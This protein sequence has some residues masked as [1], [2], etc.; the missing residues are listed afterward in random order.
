VSDSNDGNTA[1]T[2]RLG[3]VSTPAAT[4]VGK[5]GTSAEIYDAL[6]SCSLCGTAVLLTNVD[7]SAPITV[8]L[9]GTAVND[10]NTAISGADGYNFKIGGSIQ[11]ITSGT[12]PEP[13]SFFLAGVG[14]LGVLGYSM[15]RRRTKA[16]TA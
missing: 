14:S 13:S 10:L 11:G 6:G 1:L 16:R 8:I 9:K 5:S 2:W 3:S 7:S 12:V 15:L 4:L